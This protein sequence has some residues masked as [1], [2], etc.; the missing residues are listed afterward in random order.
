[1]C[2]YY[3]MFERVSRAVPQPHISHWEILLTVLSCLSCVTR[4]LITRPFRSASRIKPDKSPS[5]ATK[6]TQSRLPAE[7]RVHECSAKLCAALSIVGAP[8]AGPGRPRQTESQS[9]KTFI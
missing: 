5:T 9:R 6:T 4:N 3:C 2:M 7:I 1:M 8:I